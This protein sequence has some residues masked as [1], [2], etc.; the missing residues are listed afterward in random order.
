M[1]S[2]LICK[3]ALSSKNI[4]NQIAR[5]C[6][7]FLSAKIAPLEDIFFVCNPMQECYCSYQYVQI[8]CRV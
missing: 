1:Q 7:F 4:H 5:N 3:P 6:N 2:L 8:K